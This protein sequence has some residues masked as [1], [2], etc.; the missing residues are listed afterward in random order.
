MKAAARVFLQT[1][2]SRYSLETSLSSHYRSC[3]LAQLFTMEEDKRPQKLHLCIPADEETQPLWD[4]RPSPE[5]ANYRGQ[6][7]SGILHVSQLHQRRKSLLVASFF[8]LCASVIIF[9]PH[10]ARMVPPVS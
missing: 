4:Q 1:A 5:R 3:F 7:T 2:S 6:L 10:L 9:K 8:L